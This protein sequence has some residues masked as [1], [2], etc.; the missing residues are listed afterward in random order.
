MDQVAGGRLLS[1]VIVQFKYITFCSLLLLQFINEI[2]MNQWE[3]TDK[4][5]RS[6]IRRLDQ[7]LSLITCTAAFPW[8]IM[9]TFW[10]FQPCTE[11]RELYTQIYTHQAEQLLWDQARSSNNELAT[12]NY[13]LNKH[14]SVFT[15]RVKK[16]SLQ[17]LALV[18]ISHL[19]PKTPNLVPGN[20][21][22]LGK[23]TSSPCLVK[24]GDAGL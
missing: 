22:H 13:N 8:M 18:G 2:S 3:K 23:Q 17:K 20:F 19:Q 14:F 1:P 6:G 24:H 4:K 5:L 11:V 7:T 12:D 15:N 16:W 9:Y 21:V 10:P